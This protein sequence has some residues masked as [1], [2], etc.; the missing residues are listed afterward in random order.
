MTSAARLLPFVAAALG[1]AAC[2]EN[3]ADSATRPSPTPAPTVSD[4]DALLAVNDA[5]VTCAQRKD[6]L[7]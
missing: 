6:Q 5:F 7:A 1:F 4:A 3:G 2:G